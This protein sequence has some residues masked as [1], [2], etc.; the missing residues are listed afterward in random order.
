MVMCRLKKHRWH[1]KIL[2][3]ADPLT[4][5]ALSALCIS[6]GVSFRLG[7]TRT[8]HRHPHRILEP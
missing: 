2:K 8:P 7:L 1:Q 4:I 3:S 6:L 5:C